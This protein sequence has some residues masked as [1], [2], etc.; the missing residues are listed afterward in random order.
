[1][2]IDHILQQALQACNVKTGVLLRTR[3]ILP[4]IYELLWEVSRSCIAPVSIADIYMA[5]SDPS[6]ESLFGERIAVSR[7]MEELLRNVVEMDSMIIISE[8]QN[9][10]QKWAGKRDQELSVAIAFSPFPDNAE[11]FE[12]FINSNALPLPAFTAAKQ[13]LASFILGQIVHH[14]SDS[15]LRNKRVLVTAGPTQ[16]PID[17]V[18]FISSTSSGGLGSEIADLLF[19]SGSKVQTFLGRGATITPQFAQYSWIRTPYDLLEEVKKEIQSAEI[20]VFAA[21]VL[22]YIPKSPKTTK[23]P[24]GLGEWTIEL[25]QTPKIISFARR[26]NPDAILVGFKLLVDVSEQDLLNEGKNR[27]EEVD[28]LIANDLRKVAENSHEAFILTKTTVQKANKKHEIAQLIKS[29]LENL[30]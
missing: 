16:G 23:T 17:A 28:I 9:K 22:D 30:L 15:P 20:I 5:F 8:I 2:P 29:E 24:S 21:A 18:R 7:S 6:W 14:L 1:M 25:S 10:P 13:N 26:S 27:L 19:L 3:K 4:S 12:A 11:E